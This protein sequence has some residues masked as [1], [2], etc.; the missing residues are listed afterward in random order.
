MAQVKPD[1]LIV[2]AGVVGLM[3]GYEAVKRGARVHIMERNERAGR[4][5]SWAAAGFLRQRITTD[6]PYGWIAQTSVETYPRLAEELQDASGVDPEYRA[7]GGLQIALTEASRESLRRLAQFQRSRGV[8]VEW[9]EPKGVVEMEP[10]LTPDSLG[11]CFYPGDA[12]IRP[13]RFLRALASAFERLGGKIYLGEAAVRLLFE[14]DR[15]VGAQAEAHERRAQTTLLAAGC[16]SGKLAEKAG[17]FLPTRP[18]RGQVL[19]MEAP[20]GAL[21][22]VVSAEETYLAQRADGTFIVG[23][24]V[25]EEGFDKSVTAEGVQRLREGA[26]RAAPGLK[27]G[28]VLQ[29]WSGLRPAPARRYPYIGEMRPGLWVAT[30][31]YKVGWLLAPATARLAADGILTGETP[32]PLDDFNPER[33]R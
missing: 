19:R 14:K 33:D 27:G 31:H 1:I 20:P 30:G 32:V 18:M 21:S 22:R 24:T 4:E 5:A 25:E 28:R 9:L 15:C 11:G 17:V 29:A 12:Q 6:D 13:P 7:C 2:G 10:L 26:F 23:A 16:W 3:A 8:S